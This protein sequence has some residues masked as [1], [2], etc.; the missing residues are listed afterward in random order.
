MDRNR[1]CETVEID[2]DWK[3]E[4]LLADV[5]KKIQKRMD[6]LSDSRVRIA[7]LLTFHTF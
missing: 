6:S 4:I 2:D 7:L 5:R 3:C 1:T